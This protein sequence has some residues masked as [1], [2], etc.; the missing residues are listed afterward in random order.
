[1]LSPAV[2]Q[3]AG[4][5]A[6][7]GKAG[8]LVDGAGKFY[9]P[10]QNSERGERERKFYEQV[11]ADEDVP[12]HVKAFFPSFYGTMQIE[13][14]DGS[15]PSEHVVLEDL[16]NK[17]CQPCVIDIKMGARTWY[18][19]ASEK[20][21]AK[22]KFKDS[23]TTS[24]ALGFRVCGLQVYDAKT[25][26]VWKPD[27]IWCK[28][29]TADTVRVVLKRFVSSNPMDDL[30]P[31]AAF[32][33]AVYGGSEGIMNQLMELRNWFERQ[34]YYHFYSS[35]FLFIYEANSTHVGNMHASVR[36][37]DFAHALPGQESVDEN[38]LQGLNSLLSILQEIAHERQ[39]LLA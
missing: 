8:P 33:S 32:A 4:H 14:S 6:G 9:K 7:V 27:H 17:Y 31:D 3:V 22:C 25:K 36:L 12:A 29:L 21:V 26:N 1:M 13:A 30:H 28:M 10:L 20:Y 23:E 16:T 5:Q 19:G 34:T 11:W 18:P 38:F 39:V 37:V 15:G 35:S 24:P 2:N